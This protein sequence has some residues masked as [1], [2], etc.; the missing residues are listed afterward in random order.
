M[1]AKKKPEA[2][3]DG[4]IWATT[5]KG[6]GAATGGTPIRLSL[7]DLTMQ[8]MLQLEAWFGEA[9]GTPAEL[10]RL[11]LTTNVKGMMAAVWIG[12]QKAGRGVEDARTLDFNLDEHFEALEDPQPPAKEKKADPPT[13]EETPSSSS[14]GASAA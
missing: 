13:V 14:D 9:C 6:P 12:L 11:I 10:I 7:A 4:V 2:R 5:Y 3:T 8:R 1:P